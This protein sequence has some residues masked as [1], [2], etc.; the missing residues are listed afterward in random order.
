MSILLSGN[1]NEVYYFA[2]KVWEPG[3]GGPLACVFQ[4]VFLITP[5]NICTWKS[6]ECSAAGP[7]KLRSTN[8]CTHTE[9]ESIEWQRYGVIA[10][11]SALY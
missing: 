9:M 2:K 1:N 6:R 7:E 8:R 4:S 10:L 3:W 11:I 5:I